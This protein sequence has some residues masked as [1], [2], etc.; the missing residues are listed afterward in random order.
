[1]SA[2]AISNAKRRKKEILKELD[3]INQFLELAEKFSGEGASTSTNPTGG[4]SPKAGGAKTGEIVAAS[5]KVIQVHDKPMNRSEILSKLEEDGIIVSGKDRANT[6]G[7]TLSRAT[8]KIV[9][10]KGF[11]YWLRESDYELAGYQA[12]APRED[13]TVKR[14]AR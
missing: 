8:D 1:M 11:G 13:G 14:F 6:L 12:N 2:K 7:T 3:E 9:Y 4:G 5:R 10:L